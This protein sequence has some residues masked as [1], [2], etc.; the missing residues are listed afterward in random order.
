MTAAADEHQRTMAFANVALGQIKALRQSASPRNFEIWYTYATGHCPSLNQT[1]NE[2]LA[3]T[4]GLFDTDL[5][6]LHETYISPRRLSERID[7]VN[8]QVMDEIDQ[9]TAMVSA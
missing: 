8:S 1:I 3:R 2:M 5:E 6:V 4:G 7:H 9:L